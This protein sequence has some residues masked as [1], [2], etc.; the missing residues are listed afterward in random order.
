MYKPDTATKPRKMVRKKTV[1]QQFKR[2]N[3]APDSMGAY[4]P[5]TK[6][7]G[8]GTGDYYYRPYSQ[9]T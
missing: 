2:Y 7:R 1:D 8:R 4:G 3:A 5:R 6:R 9:K